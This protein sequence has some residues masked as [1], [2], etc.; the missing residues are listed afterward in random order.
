MLALPRLLPRN[1]D[2]TRHAEYNADYILPRKMFLE[3]EHANR[4]KQNH[5]RGIGN[6]DTNT[7]VPACPVR[8][9]ESHFYADDGRTECVARPV[10]LLQLLT[11]ACLERHKWQYH[12]AQRQCRQIRH[13]RCHKRVCAMWD[14]FLRHLIDDVGNDNQ[15][16]RENAHIFLGKKVI[17]N[18]VRRFRNVSVA[19]VGR[20]RQKFSYNLLK[21]AIPSR[22]KPR[23]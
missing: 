15:D 8:K 2:H 19:T 13:N 12:Q 7:D 14:G 23:D 22:L 3:K 1:Q 21:T 11:N 17:K 4:H 18:P 16:D 9:E 6:H 5:N 20:V 10:Q